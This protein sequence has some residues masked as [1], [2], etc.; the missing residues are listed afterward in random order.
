MVFIIAKI[1]KNYQSENFNSILLI[2]L[3]LLAFFQKS[4]VFLQLF[5]HSFTLFF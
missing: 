5:F 1:G 4:G 2:F 3:L